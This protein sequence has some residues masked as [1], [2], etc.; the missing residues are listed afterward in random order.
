MTDKERALLLLVA[1]HLEL[2]L[3]DL[4]RTAGLS[5]AA[6]AVEDEQQQ[7]AKRSWGKND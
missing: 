6:R 4:G 7:L 3:G 2:V 5:E 1:K